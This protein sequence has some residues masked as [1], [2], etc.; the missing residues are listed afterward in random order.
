MLFVYFYSLF[1]S[2][3]FNSLN[4]IK[5]APVRSLSVEIS[6]DP[7]LKTTD[8]QGRLLVILSTDSTAEPRFQVNDG[9]RSQQI[10]GLDVNSWRSPAQIKL[11][12]SVLGYP[13]ASLNEI[14]AGTYWAQAVL[15]LYE[16]VQLQTGQTIKVPMD[17]GEGQHWN[18][19]PGNLYSIPVKILIKKAGI[20]TFKIFLS[21]RIPPITE[22]A[23]TKYIKHVRIQSQL[24]TRFWGRPM[25]VGAHVLLPEGFDEHPDVHYPLAIF[26]G[27]FPDDFGGFRTSPPDTTLKPDYNERFKLKGY[28]IIQQQEAY[29]FYKKWTGPGFP[30]VLAIEIQHPTPYYDDSYAVNSASQGPWGDALT[31]ELIPYIENKFRGIGKGWARFT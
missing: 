1:T 13:L 21:Q 9:L 7:N 22:P 26:H 18:Q 17:R 30:R 31:Y 19:A 16:T 5:V 10:F 12:E 11:N 8:L 27:H 28:N 20:Q 6:V 23:D 29:D 25:Y 2:L 4:A 15:H 3:V 24:L 14:P